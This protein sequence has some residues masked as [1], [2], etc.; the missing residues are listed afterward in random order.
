[1]L[2][3]TS[4]HVE[5]IADQL[6]RGPRHLCLR[7][8]HNIAFGLTVVTDDKRYPMA[9][10]WQMVT[11]L[12]QAGAEDEATI[13][14]KDLRGDLLT[15][16][17]DLSSKSRLPEGACGEPLHY[18]E[19][20]AKRFQVSRKTI[21]RW[22][23]R[24][25]CAWKVVGADGRLRV[26][27]AERCVRIFVQQNTAL[28]ERAAN[29]TQLTETDVEQIVERARGVLAAGARSRNAVIEQV[30]QDVG[31]ARETVRQIL[32]RHEQERPEQALFSEPAP[33]TAADWE[34]LRIWEACQDGASVA[35]IAERFDMT[36]KQAYAIVTEMRAGSLK[37]QE[38]EFID[39]D[40]F[41]ETGADETIRSN[42]AG[43]HPYAASTTKRVPR[44]LPP[45][46]QELYRRP[47]LTAEGEQALF[48][49]MNYLKYRA[50]VRREALD[51]ETATAS[52]LDQIEAL[53]AEAGELKNQIICANLRLV[54][55]VARR[56]VGD[57][58]DLF[59]LISDGNET[60]M[61]AV[62]RFDFNRGFKFSTYCTWALMR[63]FARRGYEVNRRRSLF[64]TGNEDCLRDV[65]AATP[66]TEGDLVTREL[67]EQMASELSDRQWQVLRQRFGLGSDG[68]PQTL[69]EIGR[70]LGV[71]KE[72]VR[73][74]ETESIAKLREKFSGQVERL[75]G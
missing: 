16:A 5:N 4:R 54:V 19:T 36:P 68:Q 50:D 44:E 58:K 53:L 51:P 25:L 26:A 74:I 66:S 30:A 41:R 33:S 47:L 61:R 1:M 6:R 42:P 32:M 9:F 2:R 73:Q 35:S 34:R 75:M 59:D 70:D 71:S 60:L 49:K 20:L 63:R 56:H 37:R 22:R 64:V 12:K 62:D 10:V 3:Y 52:D 18:P 8:L 57:G 29:F 72:R 38:V 45:L 55:H 15:L 48:R 40:T 13:R 46:L 14:G 7:H 27:F 23:D 43:L 21:S 24:G 69:T 39:S 31:R 65:V 17:E 11:G 67:V 28:I